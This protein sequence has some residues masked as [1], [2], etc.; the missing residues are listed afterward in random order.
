MP[1]HAHVL[2]IISKNKNLSKSSERGERMPDIFSE[3]KTLGSEP[4]HAGLD[5]HQRGSP[6]DV[7]LIG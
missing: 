7:S 2:G 5:H 1:N 3:Q 6:G 4:D